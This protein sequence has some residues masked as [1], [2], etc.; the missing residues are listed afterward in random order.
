MGG[1]P[2][3]QEPCGEGG[4]FSRGSAQLLPAARGGHHGLLGTPSHIE[5]RNLQPPS[6]T[7]VPAWWQLRRDAWR[8]GTCRLRRQPTLPPSTSL[9]QT[10]GRAQQRARGNLCPL[11]P[12]PIAQRGCRQPAWQRWPHRGPQR[13]VPPSVAGP[14]EDPLQLPMLTLARAHT[15]HPTL[16]FSFPQHPA[17]EGTSGKLARETRP[18]LQLPPAAYRA[19]GQL[20]NGDR[21]ETGTKGTTGA[22]ARPAAP[23]GDRRDLVHL[24]MKKQAPGNLLGCWI[25]GAVWEGGGVLGGRGGCGGDKGSGCGSRNRG[26]KRRRWQQ[27]D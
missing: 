27:L 11:L 20:V 10:G 22:A 23:A 2:A 24:P 15:L 4:C 6:G 16:L 25:V 19:P 14:G 12:R 17:A 9:P 3:P 13:T 18:D 7:C 1:R 5:V 26:S 21:G 8:G